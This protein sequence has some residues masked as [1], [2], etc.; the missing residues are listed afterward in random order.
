MLAKVMGYALNGLEGFPVDVEV[1]VHNGLPVFE[2]VGL[3]DTAV[4]ESK[5][6]V[7]SA[8]K[9]SGRTFPVTRI[10]VNLAPADMKKE[11]A[12]LDLPIAIGILKTYS[13]GF[14]SDI[15]DYVLLGELSL[16]GSIRAVK[17]I[18]PLLISAFNHGYKQFI[19]PKENEK[20]AS[21]IENINV[22]AASNLNQVI[23]HLKGT[24]LLP[25]VEKRKYLNGN[26]PINLCM[27]D[28]TWTC[29]G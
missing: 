8:I 15:T 21:Y 5:E 14:P 28:D 19:I 29:R 23:E 16:D 9:N 4:K 7:R 27:T 3:P 26:K 13:A 20:E 22:Y 12:Y 25:V 1:D 2:I 6:R 11:G 10:T 17:G 18:L 24:D